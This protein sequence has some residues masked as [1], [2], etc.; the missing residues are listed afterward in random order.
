[1][2]KPT[3]VLIVDDSP[4][5][6]RLLVESLRA[7]AYRI[8]IAFDGMQGYDRAVAQ[9]PDIILL[10][11]Q[12][13]KMDGFALCRQ[14]KAN[15]HTEHIPIIFLTA[16]GE[17]DQRLIGLEEGGVDYVTKPF[18]PEE[19]LA[20]LR[21]HLRLAGRQQAEE[22]RAAAAVSPTAKENKD[23]TQVLAAK[24]FLASR[25]ADPPALDELAALIGSSPK[26]LT[27]A[28]RQLEGNTV[29][30]FLRDKRMR[31]AQRLLSETSLAISAISQEV[32]FSSPANFS[33]AFLEHTGVS[34][35]AYRDGAVRA[36]PKNRG[37]P[38]PD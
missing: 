30:G 16:M 36:K 25:L 10:D 24:N 34:P 19:V 23:A 9:Q 31:T 1:M 29:F 26:R 20:R 15:P 17:L 37:T 21:I 12:M 2:P 3:H 27:R 35:S 14:L 18:S 22:E 5:Q 13:P 38:Q 28:F 7:D 32:G 8:S 11:V 33:T 4:D 6:L